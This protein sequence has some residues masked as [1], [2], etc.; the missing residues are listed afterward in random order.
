MDRCTAQC[1]Y[2]SFVSIGHQAPYTTV[3]LVGE[4]SLLWLVSSGMIDGDSSQEENEKEVAL[5]TKMPDCELK[6]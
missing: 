6:Q 1:D 2:I 5:L 4:Q 3:F